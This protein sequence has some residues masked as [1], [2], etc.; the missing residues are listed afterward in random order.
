MI[1]NVTPI[2][3]LVRNTQWYGKIHLP[4]VPGI[5]PWLQKDLDFRRTIPNA[6]N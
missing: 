2:M 5:P 1:G 3:V 4:C 6:L